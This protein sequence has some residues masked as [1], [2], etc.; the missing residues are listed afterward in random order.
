MSARYGTLVQVSQ[1]LAQAFLDWCIAQGFFHE[2]FSF[3][4]PGECVTGLEP[5]YTGIQVTITPIRGEQ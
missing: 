2:P 4:V 3:I 1:F 5:G